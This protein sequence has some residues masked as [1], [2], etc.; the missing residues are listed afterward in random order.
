MTVES[1]RML[2]TPKKVFQKFLVVSSFSVAFWN[3]LQ[4]ITGRGAASLIQATVFGLLFS[5]TIPRL[6]LKLASTPKFFKLF[7]SVC[8]DN[9]F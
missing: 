3:R 1:P 4:A 2:L 9:L 7:C 6:C 5:T 8:L